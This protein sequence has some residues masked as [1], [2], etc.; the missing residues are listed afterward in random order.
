[1]VR[2]E[3]YSKAGNPQPKEKLIASLKAS[4]FW[5]FGLLLGVAFGSLCAWVIF[6]S[7]KGQGVWRPLGLPNLPTTLLQAD[8]MASWT[9]VLFFA[10]ILLL[11]VG[12]LVGAKLGSW[13]S[14]VCSLFTVACF[15]PLVWF[16]PGKGRQA[17]SSLGLPRNAP[18]GRYIGLGF[19]AFLME[20]PLSLIMGQLGKQIFP[21]QTSF[22]PVEVALLSSHDALIIVALGLQTSVL[23]PLFEELIFRGLMLPAIAQVSGSLMVS[24]GITSFIFASIHPQGLGA[25]LGLATIAAASCTLVYHTRSIAPS[26]VMHGLHNAFTLA[27]FLI[28]S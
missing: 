12:Q 13:G 22:H 17:F 15:F 27:F 26:F 10:Y 9:A 8:R 1:M 20:Y 3:L 18:W 16:G 21:D 14:I 25:W 23:A 4:H 6:I 2:A 7:L 19:A 5:G 24:I 11:T 28:L